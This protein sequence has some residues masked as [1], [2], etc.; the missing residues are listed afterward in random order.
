M[1]LKVMATV[2]VLLEGAGVRRQLSP[3]FAHARW[4]VC[5]D[6]DSGRELWMDNRHRGAVATAGAMIRLGVDRLVCIWVHA[7]SLR[8]LR[9]AGVDVRLAPVTMPAAAALACADSLPV[10]CEGGC[11]SLMG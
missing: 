3:L 8:L 11:D 2:A 4:L 7:E 10:A 6:R 5:I 9:T 1:G